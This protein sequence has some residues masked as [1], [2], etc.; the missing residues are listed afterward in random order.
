[1]SS[2]SA[3]FKLDLRQTIK[4][5]I[6]TLLLVNFALYIADDIRV[7]SY[8]MRN[9]GTLLQWTSAFATTI[10]ESAWFILLLLFELETYILS[11]EIQRRPGVL[12]LVHGLRLLCYASLTHSVYAFGLTYL[13]LTQVTAISGVTELCQLL[14][15][16]ISFVR[17]LEYTDLNSA[18]CGALSNTSA[19]FF[20]EQELVVTDA[21][22]LALETRLAL[23]DVLEVV[24]WLAILFTIEV[25]VWLQDR[26]ITR[27][28]I[29]TCIKWAK[30]VL[31]TSLWCAAAYWLSLGHF[32][33]AWDEALWIVGFFA[34][35][36]NVSEWKKEIEE[37]QAGA[38]ETA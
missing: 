20:T 4:L 3:P 13:D 11:D 32:Y 23:V 12:L 8:T 35:E 29:I 31:Y 34:I 9:G 27:S 36:M 24:V 10:D 1:M 37:T 16:D 6:Y 28:K 17:N 18:N 26:D 38:P 22:G 14:G 30:Y 21:S 25:M 19:F 33:F 15:N 2:D 5:V 7:A